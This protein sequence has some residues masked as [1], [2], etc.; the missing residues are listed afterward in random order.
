LNVISNTT[1]IW[2][3]P[4]RPGMPL[5]EA[6]GSPAPNDFQWTIGYC[7][8]SGLANWNTDVG[9]FKSHSPVKLTNTK[10]YW[11]LA[12]DTLISAGRTTWAGTDVASGP[13]ATPRNQIVYNN[14]P[15]HKRGTSTAG[16]NEVFADGSAA[17]QK[18]DYLNWNCLQNWSGALSTTTEV[19][20]RQDT[21]DY[22][23]NLLSVLPALR[24]STSLP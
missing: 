1:S 8:L 15:P 21:A 18:W 12:V 24:P 17:W 3:C 14:C 2:T 19:Y 22:E 4:D 13:D 7:C 6:T 16:A 5:H 9:V 10:P 20:W 23:P 11:V